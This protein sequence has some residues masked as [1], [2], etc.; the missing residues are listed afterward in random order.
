MSDLSSPAVEKFI[1]DY[2]TTPII[3][4]L[5]Q[6]GNE[7]GVVRQTIASWIK[8]Y[9][10]DIEEIRQQ[11][12]TEF[13]MNLQRTRAKALKVV[14]EALDAKN[15]DTALKMMPYYTPKKDALELSGDVNVNQ[16]I[17]ISIKKL[18][19]ESVDVSTGVN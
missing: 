12:I 16:P 19:Q 18:K 14:D 4:T 17:A 3:K 15:L 1:L 11:D 8:T 7:Y 10:T 2:A 6:W 13:N 9:A 5:E